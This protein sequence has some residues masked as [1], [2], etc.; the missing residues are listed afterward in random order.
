MFYFASSQNLSFFV[1]DLSCLFRLLDSQNISTSKLTLYLKFESEALRNSKQI[2][3]PII[4]LTILIIILSLKVKNEKYKSDLSHQSF[5]LDDYQQRAV[6]QI[7]KYQILTERSA[8]ERE[9]L[10]AINKISKV[11]LV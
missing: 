3:T 5:K 6:V 9:E 8:A 7:E 1:I 2:L 10:Q 11:R 4:I